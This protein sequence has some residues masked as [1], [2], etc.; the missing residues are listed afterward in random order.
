MIQIDDPV[1]L[2]EDLCKLGLDAAHEIVYG[3][4]GYQEG[5]D[6]GTDFFRLRLQILAV[7]IE[8]GRVLSSV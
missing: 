2:A 1:Q 3:P 4:H 5:L 6:V 8:S 7:Q